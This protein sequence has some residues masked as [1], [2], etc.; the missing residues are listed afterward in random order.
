MSKDNS[1]SAQQKA[2]ASRWGKGAKLAALSN[3]G[4]A[5]TATAP[6]THTFLDVVASRRALNKLWA[7]LLRHV[8]ACVV[9]IHILRDEH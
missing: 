1:D 4:G 5:A 3:G 6:L 9:K 8:H 7:R 2:E